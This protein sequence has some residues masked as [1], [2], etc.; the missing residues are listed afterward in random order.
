M[1]LLIML[2]SLLLFFSCSENIFDKKFL[3]FELRLAQS[4]M[5]PPVN[6]MVLYK[7]D[8]KFFVSD[9]IFLNN[10]DIKSAGVIDWQ[11]H[12]KV[13]VLLNEEGRKKFADFTE[14]HIGK[15]AAI[16]VGHKLI[17]APK[18]NASIRGGILLI[19]GHLDHEEARGIAE[20]IVIE[21]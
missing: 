16:L 3:L 11:T 5:Y 2:L 1:K 4:E 8:Q 21:N 6:E 20:G 14:K 9:S 7:T 15:N 13:K 19:V 10:E 12:P 17:S 18:I